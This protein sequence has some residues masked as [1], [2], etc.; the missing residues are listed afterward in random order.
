MAVE[1]EATTVMKM[2]EPLP[3][4]AQDR[5]LEHLHEYIAELKDKM[6]WDESFERTQTNLVSAAKQVR[7]QISVGKSMPLKI[8]KL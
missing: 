6:Q 4:H 7:K 3:E 8:D 2:L 5:V 1:T